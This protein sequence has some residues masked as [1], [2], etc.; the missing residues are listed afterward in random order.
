MI[1]PLASQPGIEVKAVHRFQDPERDGIASSIS[2]SEGM[3]GESAK[4]LAVPAVL[5]DTNN[6]KGGGRREVSGN[7]QRCTLHPQR[8]AVLGGGIKLAGQ[9]PPHLEGQPSKAQERRRQ[10]RAATKRSKA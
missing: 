9:C 10:N 4:A 5:Q 6:G 7:S 8:V 2:Q 1:F 3:S